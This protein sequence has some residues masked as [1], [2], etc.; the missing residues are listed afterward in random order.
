MQACGCGRRVDTA[1]REPDSDQ[2]RSSP[3]FRDVADA[4]VVVIAKVS[5]FDLASATW[6]LQQQDKRLWPCLQL[7]GQLAAFPLFLIA[8]AAFPLL[9]I[10]GFE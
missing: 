5:F 7:A 10:L 3:P 2:P 6:L 1:R 8:L 9:L 4:A